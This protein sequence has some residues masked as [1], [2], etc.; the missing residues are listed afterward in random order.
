MRVA[1]IGAGLTGAYTAFLLARSGAE[2]LCLDPLD[3]PGRASDVNPGG[4]NPLH[5]PG[6]PG[7]LSQFALHC[8]RLHMQQWDELCRLSGVD[9]QGR[10]VSR[11]LLAFSAAELETLAASE[12]LYCSTP[13]FEA[14][15]LDRAG[16]AELRQGI[17]PDAL[18]GVLTSGNATVDSAR[19]ARALLTAAQKLG[20]TLVRDTVEGVVSMGT[21]LTGVRTARET[22]SLDQAVFC[23]GPRSFA[24]IE[25][26]ADATLPVRAVKGELLTARLD[27][28]QYRH[29]VTW[30]QF[31]LYHAGG[32]RYWLGG[33]QEN[34]GPDAA[35][36][37]QAARV[38]LE[39]IQTMMPSISRAALVDQQFGLRPMTPDGL[40]VLGR[41]TH[42]D[43][44]YIAN[45]GGVKGVLFSAGMAE[46]IARLINGG[47]ETAELA[48]LS[49]GRFRDVDRG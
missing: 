42:W 14:R 2:V 7:P 35:T 31:G 40:P 4:L 33:T 41:L 1:V 26:L 19:Y 15:I 13:G 12:T 20:A 11:L 30:R 36:T 5:G 10:T 49:P 22:F 3:T 17:N 44:L 6:I 27:A 28:R 18:G 38:I 32:D 21:L 23:T 34:C 16:L 39:G 47:G 29:D 8:H 46:T 43:N 48:I 45:G 25:G 9:F 24:D 37:P